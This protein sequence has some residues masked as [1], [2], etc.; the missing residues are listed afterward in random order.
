MRSNSNK[1][2]THNTASAYYQ[3]SAHFPHHLSTRPHL[4]YLHSATLNKH[5]SVTN[6]GLVRSSW[7]PQRRPIF[8]GLSGCRLYRVFPFLL[9]HRLVSTIY[10]RALRTSFDFTTLPRCADEWLQ[11]SWSI[12]HLGNWCQRAMHRKVPPPEQKNFFF[13]LNFLSALCSKSRICDGTR[14]PRR[15]AGHRSNT[16]QGMI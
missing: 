3:P 5:A 11:P 7:Q 10:T 1:W 13:R 16:T 14:P 12:A 4:R 8:C 2:R 6:G 9:Q 15:A